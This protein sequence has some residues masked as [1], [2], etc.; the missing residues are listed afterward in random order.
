[1]RLRVAM[2]AAALAAGAVFVLAGAAMA[3]GRPASLTLYDQPDYRG[4]SVTFYGD[5]ANVG[6][7]GFAD[8]AESAQV[9]GSWRVCEGG[10]YRNHCEVLSGNV[11]DLSAYGLAGRVGSA[12]LLGAGPAAAYTPPPAATYTPPVYAPPASTAPAYEPPVYAPAAPAQDGY[13]RQGYGR[14]DY[15]ADRYTPPAYGSDY[16]PRDY[17]YGAAPP[18]PAV[19][20][21]PPSYPDQAYAEP[22][23]ARPGFDGRATVFFPHPLLRGREVVYW[24][25]GAADRFCRAQGLGPAVYSDQ[26]PGTAV[27]G[28]VLRD[29]LCRRG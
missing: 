1:M 20:A 29:V 6:S 26:E 10:G 9:L 4:G 19:D 11:R 5:N 14:D 7:T 25:Q 17:G 16:P 8:R 2:P 22:P 21:P 23:V 18:P 15:G 13:G 3:Q 28:P 27:T 12:Q 24:G